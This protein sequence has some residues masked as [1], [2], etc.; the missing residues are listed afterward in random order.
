[1]AIENGIAVFSLRLP[2]E[3][4]SQIDQRAKVSRRP[5]N[6]EIILLLEMAIDI[7]VQRDLKLMEDAKVRA[8]ASKP[9]N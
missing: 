2:T 4:A 3:L 5:R 9:Q 7:A 1:M 8:E 6:S